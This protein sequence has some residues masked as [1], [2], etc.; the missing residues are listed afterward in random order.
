M[1]PTV[2][3]FDD[4]PAVLGNVSETNDNGSV[5]GNAQTIRSH[6]QSADFPVQRQNADQNIKD[7]IKAADGAKDSDAVDA[8]NSAQMA[9]L[10]AVASD[11]PF[12]RGHNNSEKQLENAVPRS[13][14]ASSVRNA[15]QT[16]NAA[17]ACVDS[18]I[19]K[20]RRD[21]K[22]EHDQ[23]KQKNKEAKQDGAD[24]LTGCEFDMDETARQLADCSAL[25]ALFHSLER[26]RPGA[27][28]IFVRALLDR[29]MMSSAKELKNASAEVQHN[30]QSQQCREDRYNEGSNNEISVAGDIGVYLEARWRRKHQALR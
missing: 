9:S 11:L 30:L 17:A 24:Q 21:L 29:L 16:G 8:A 7:D 23:R 14:T 22:I 2:W 25:S 18:A 19:D 3:D 10:D 20:L 6:R 12:S 15:K 26:S 28:D 13:H 4:A 1:P 27:V 5:G